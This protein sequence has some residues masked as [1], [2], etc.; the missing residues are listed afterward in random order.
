MSEWL[1]ELVLKTNVFNNTA[2]SNPALPLMMN[3]LLKN[4]KNDIDNIKSIINII[5]II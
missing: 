2:G 4:F 5:L 3:N 1:K